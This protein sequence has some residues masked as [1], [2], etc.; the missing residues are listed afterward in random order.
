MRACLPLLSFLMSVCLVLCSFIIFII[1]IIIQPDMSIIVVIT[2][3]TQPD[4]SVIIIIAQPDITHIH[5][6]MIHMYV[7]SY[8]HKLNT[9]NCI[10]VDMRVCFSRICSEEERETSFCFETKQCLI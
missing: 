3:I 6:I 8:L 9:L 5:P 7:Y 1:I 2:T 4:M 10:F